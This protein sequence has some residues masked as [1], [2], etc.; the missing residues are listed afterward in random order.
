[1][2]D[3]YDMEPVRQPRV[4]KAAA[5]FTG[6]KL[7][8]S[9]LD[10]GVTETDVK[11][12]FSDVGELKSYRLILDEYSQSTGVAEV[13]YKSK[14][15]AM[16]A[17]DRYHG[18][19]LDGRPMNIKKVANAE[20]GRGSVL[21]RLSTGPRRGGGAGAASS[22][23]A[24]PAAHSDEEESED[25]AGGRGG[26]RGRG[27]GSDDRAWRERSGRGG[28]RGGSRGGGRGASRGEAR[29]GRGRGRGREA[30][31]QV[32]EGDLDDDLGSYFNN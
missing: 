32:Q 17:I 11:D 22:G 5:I 12:L 20:T 7:T 16:D 29:G 15:D 6:T 4:R 27:G 1:M 13:V 25:S 8:V 14:Q 9:N 10:H 18:V 21:D 3:E 26:G 23:R 31:P 30:R 2:D 19:P 24:R 28:G